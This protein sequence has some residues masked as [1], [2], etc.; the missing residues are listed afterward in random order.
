MSRTRN[1]SLLLLLL[2]F[3]PFLLVHSPT[4]TP[5][6]AFG[7]LL[8]AF[9][10][11][12][13]SSFDFLLMCFGCLL[14][15]VRCQCGFEVLLCHCEWLRCRRYVALATAVESSPTSRRRNFKRRAAARNFSQ[16]VLIA[17]IKIHDHYTYDSVP[18]DSTYSRQCHPH[19]HPHPYPHRQRITQQRHQRQSAQCHPSPHQPHSRGPLP[20]STPSVKKHPGT[21]KSPKDNVSKL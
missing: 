11:P 10:L 16:S 13:L 18:S 12:S 9:R 8:D 20:K 19:P 6:A 3:A 17:P 14:G 21:R 2:Q 5:S 1:L 15:R 7:S 4:T